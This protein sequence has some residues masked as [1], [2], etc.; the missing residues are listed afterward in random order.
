M[1][2]LDRVLLCARRYARA[3]FRG[4]ADVDDL[5]C[6][7][8]S[9]AWELAKAAGMRHQPMAYVRFAVRRVKERRQ[10]RESVRSIDSFVAVRPC[11]AKAERDDGFDVAEFFDHADPADIAAFRID[12]T[13]WLDSLPLRHRMVAELLAVGNT[14]GEVARLLGCSPGNV[15]QF[16]VKL[17]ESWREFVNEAT[18]G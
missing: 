6:D 8:Q 16:R 10:F 2:K 1:T 5:I 18:E 11:T 4:H 7:V 15:S 12:F 3:V 13:A 17:M 14:T 9:V